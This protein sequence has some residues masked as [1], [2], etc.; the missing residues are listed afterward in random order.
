MSSSIRIAKKSLAAV[1][2]RG[3]S[4]ATIAVGTP[5]ALFNKSSA[6]I[7]CNCLPQ[8]GFKPPVSRSD[9]Y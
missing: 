2:Q 3:R 8:P 5:Q 7:T 1:D 4:R 6:D 9:G